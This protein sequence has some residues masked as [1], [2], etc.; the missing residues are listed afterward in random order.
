M[1]KKGSKRFNS[2]VVLDS[3]LPRTAGSWQWHQESGYCCPIEVTTAFF[4]EHLGS[5]RME[6]LQIYIAKSAKTAGPYSEKSVI[7]L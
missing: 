5:Q 4:Q 1:A 2:P 7:N 6:K 3:S